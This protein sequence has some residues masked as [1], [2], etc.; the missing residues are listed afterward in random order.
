MNGDGGHAFVL[1]TVCVTVTTTSYETVTP[2]GQVLLKKVKLTQLVEKFYFFMEHKHLL[3]C[4]H[5]TYHESDENIP[6]L[7]TLFLKNSF[8]I[9]L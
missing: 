8:N 6:Y 9:I 4:T 5:Q 3:T 2:R 7:S 1:S